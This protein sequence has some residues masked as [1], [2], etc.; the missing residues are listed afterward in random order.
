MG[1]KFIVDR[2]CDVKHA[3]TLTGLIKGLQYQGLL[4]Q[5]SELAATGALA[6]CDAG[7][8][9]DLV[10]PTLD[11]VP[12]DLTIRE[13]QESTAALLEHRLACRRC[14]SSLKGQVGGC[15]G[16]IPYPISEGM[17]FLLWQTAVQG[18]TGAL[19]EALLPRVAAFAEKARAI[20]RTPF[21]DE[22]RRRGDL[23]GPRPRVYQSGPFWGKIR[24]SSSQVLDLFFRPGVAAGDELRVLAGFLF[25]SLQM[26]R[27]LEPIITDEEQKL[28]LADELLP[29]TQV[30]ELMVRA[31]QQGLGMYVWP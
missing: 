14:P 29:Y 11:R 2:R 17:E 31:L 9:V 10:M 20:R 6:E 19:P 26:G 15:I 12:P 21:T 28:S 18:L 4:R 22:L 1:A 30:Y 24:L 3:L 8:R 13:L 5:V 25:A 16:Y 7:A 23:V 27:A